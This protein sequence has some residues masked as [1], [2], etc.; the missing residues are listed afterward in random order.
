LPH[1]EPQPCD[2]LDLVGALL[3]SPGLAAIVFGLSETSSQGGIAY[4]GAWAPVLAGVVLVVAFAWHALHLRGR[5]PLLNLKLF[6]SPGFAAASVAVLLIGAVV[7]GVLL[8]V[9]LYFQVDRGASPLSTGLLL[10]P[11]GLGAALVM[12]ISGRL[13]DR[14][15]GGI[16]ALSGLVVM[17]IATVALTQLTA[18][19]SYDMTAAILAVRGVGLGCGMMPATAAA[20]ATVSDVADV[21]AATTLINTF[22]RIG[23]SIGTALLAV[24][25]EGQ[26][27]GTAPGALDA[28][29]GSLEPLPGSIRAHFATPLATAFDHT[30]WWAVALTAVATVPA[31]VLAVTT[32]RSRRAA[33]LGT[34]ADATFPLVDSAEEYGLPHPEHHRIAGKSVTQA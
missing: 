19:T 26:I 29:G 18:H 23:G 2:R 9:P 24:L 31:F 15:G 12:P 25:L 1:S 20:Y 10:A 6:R 5:A 21:P 7:F 17:T 33:N 8:V 13:T 34:Q 16:V 3:L 11:Q 4:P 30:L 27:R 28:T 14:I 22:Q 32:R